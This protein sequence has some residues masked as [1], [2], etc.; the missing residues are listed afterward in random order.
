MSRS[1]AV[2]QQVL[3]RDNHRCQIC[4][5]DEVI[6][7]HHIAPLGV[8]GS[9]EKD[10]AENMITLCGECHRKVHNNVYS[11]YAFT[12]GEELIV[13]DQASKRI[14]NSDLWFYRRQLIEKLEP[15]EA[16]IQGLHVLDGQ[17]AADLYEL[18]K[19]DN[20]LALDPEAASFKEYSE[21]RGWDTRRAM[22]LI[23][24]YKQA[25]EAD[26]DWREGQTATD[27]RH[28]IK[29]LGLT[30]P[31][32]WR[33][34]FYDTAG[35]VHVLKATDDELGDLVKMGGTAIRVGKTM[36]EVQWLED[37]ESI[38]AMMIDVIVEGGYAAQ[39]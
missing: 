3:E 27:I 1:E 14:P 33:W 20:Y 28:A 11:V 4:G 8:G 29:D 10:V 13:I 24:L 16:R 30:S 9:D 39:K 31:R 37:I 23:S 25:Q 18:W 2:R 15:I 12:P 32:Q 38:D 26:I 35:D 5:A 34:L 7:V 21:S 36:G 19:D 6:E 17:V 22:N